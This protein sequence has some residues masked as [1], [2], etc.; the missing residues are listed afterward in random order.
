MRSVVKP[1]HPLAELML[2]G[3]FGVESDWIPAKERLRA[4]HNTIK[5][6]VKWH[7]EEMAKA[8]LQFE[9]DLEEQSEEH[10][11]DLEALEGIFQDRIDDLELEAAYGTIGDLERALSDLEGRCD[12]NVSEKE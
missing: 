9:S 12:K 6:S 7:E 10:S 5:K 3:L 1:E 4:I 11:K 8:K 2:R